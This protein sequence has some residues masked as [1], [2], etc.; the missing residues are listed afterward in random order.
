MIIS[1]SKKKFFNSIF[2]LPVLKSFSFREINDFVSF[3]FIFSFIPY[4]YWA[5]GGG[6]G[7]CSLLIISLSTLLLVINRFLSVEDVN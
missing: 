5:G 6:A 4:E 7:G 1:V 3:C 2:F